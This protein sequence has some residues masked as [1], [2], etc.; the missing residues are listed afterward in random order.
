M[1]AEDHID[2]H[3]NEPLHRSFGFRHRLIA[4]VVWCWREVMV[5]HNDPRRAVLSR[6]KGLGAEVELRRLNPPVADRLPRRGRIEPDNR[7]FIEVPNPVQF[8]RD[9]LAIQ[10]V[11]V[12]QPLCDPVE[13][14]I[15]VPWDDDCRDI[16]Q[17]L[18]KV[19]GLDKLCGFGALCEIATDDDDV[20]LKLRSQPLD[21][22]ADAFHKGW[23]E[24]QVGDVQEP[25]HVA[26]CPGTPVALSWCWGAVMGP[27]FE[28]R[29]MKRTCLIFNAQAGAAHNL[30]TLLRRFMSGPHCEFRATT[31]SSDVMSQV[32]AG[33]ERGAERIIVAGGDGTVNRVVDAVADDF[34][35]IDLA[36]L[37]LGTG[38]DLARSLGVP[39]DDLDSA[40][41]L[42]FRGDSVPIDVVRVFDGHTTHLINAASAGFG[43][44]V[45][46][47]IGAADKAR[48]GAFAYWMTAVTELVNLPQFDVEVEL[49][50]RT[51]NSRVYGLTIANGRYLG[52]GFPI[53]RQALVNDGLLDIT[54]IP[55]L[56]ALE[57]L[58]AGLNYMVG[59]SSGGDRL[60]NFRSRC[61]HVSS[62]PEM[63]FSIDGDPIREVEAAF[64]VLPKALRVVAGPEAPALE[65]KSS[66]ATVLLPH[67]QVSDNSIQTSW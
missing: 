9:V 52:G 50:D 34:S 30:G 53:A 16:G 2:S 25:Q 59:I 60:P 37:P 61:V 18:E 64:E 63:L 55:V 10:S 17:T 4:F 42:A 44:Q 22:L 38:N 27:A 57:L 7:G 3:R 13:R 1:S 33:I 6:P 65:N 21:G 49:D 20:R 24:V 41:S 62:T 14:N 56:P 46:A 43:G 31:D 12:T 28:V 35:R 40:C 5:G 47:D 11:R 48:W 51:I 19:L 45:A 54:L 39:L 15:M 58:A 67:G 29:M 26:V 32:R 23:S 8:A 66:T 36:V